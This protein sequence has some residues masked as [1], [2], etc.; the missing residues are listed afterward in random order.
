MYSYT[1]SAHESLAWRMKEIN[2]TCYNLD[3]CGGESERQQVEFSNYYSHPAPKNHNLDLCL[4]FSPSFST[5]EYRVT[6]GW[7][8]TSAPM[9]SLLI[10]TIFMEFLIRIT[11][12]ALLVEWFI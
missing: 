7:H 8:H 1:C 9:I 4:S 2:Q 5:F 11:F 6:L 12:Q 3:I 10:R